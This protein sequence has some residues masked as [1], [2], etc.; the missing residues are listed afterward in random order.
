MTWGAGPHRWTQPVTGMALREGEAPQDPWPLTG[1]TGWGTSHQPRLE[2]RLLAPLSDL[3][4]SCHLSAVTCPLQHPPQPRVSLVPSAPPELMGTGSSS[5]RGQG[6]HQGP[7][8]STAMAL[9]ECPLG[10]VPPPAVPT[11]KVPPH[12]GA[13]CEVGVQGGQT[14]P[15]HCTCGGE[16]PPHPLT[17]CR[18]A[19]SSGPQP[20]CSTACT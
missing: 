16:R 2:T 5:C 4:A 20:T 1:T 6:S 11:G 9:K 19:G 18:L 3:S 7:S 17:Q 12:S 8:F 10:P 13:S 14:G 15:P